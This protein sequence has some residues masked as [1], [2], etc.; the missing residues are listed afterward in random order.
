MLNAEIQR[1]FDFF[2]NEMGYEANDIGFNIKR[3][4]LTEDE[5]LKKIEKEWETKI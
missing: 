4:D 1:D 3:L 2:F 5:E